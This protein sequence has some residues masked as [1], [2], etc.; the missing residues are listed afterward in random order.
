MRFLFILLLT[1]LPALA[2][3][4]QS[5]ARA[6]WS[7]VCD[8]ARLRQLADEMTRLE[9][10]ALDNPL[11]HPGARAA[12]SIRSHA[13]LT[14]LDT[15]LAS[16]NRN[17]CLRD[18]L[19]SRIGELWHS[20]AVPPDHA[21]LSRPPVLLRCVSFAAPI[22]ITRVDVDPA[23]LWLSMPYGTIVERDLE[24]QNVVYGG[25]SAIGTIDLGITPSGQVV[26]TGLSDRPTPCFLDDLES[27]R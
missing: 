17:R 5:S 8:D 15:C 2:D 22:H 18:Q 4:C 10:A 14:E 21:G 1:S 23:L 11:L 13:T 19:M 3:E 7:T 24:A 20:G 26:L 16:D 6:F 9:E 25:A 27:L 12:L